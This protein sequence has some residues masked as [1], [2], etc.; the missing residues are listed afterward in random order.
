VIEPINLETA[1]IMALAAECLLRADGK[2]AAMAILVTAAAIRIQT[3]KASRSPRLGP[4]TGG[5]GDLGMT[6]PEREPGLPVIENQLAKRRLLM[7]GT[8]G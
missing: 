7:T 6:L 5:A 4:M 3:T 2:L 1:L 8:A